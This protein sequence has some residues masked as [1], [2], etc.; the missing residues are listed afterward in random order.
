[1]GLA[2][3]IEA[4]WGV[5][6]HRAKRR[7]RGL[8]LELIVSVAVKIAATEELSAVSMNRVAADLGVSPMSLY[9]YVEAKEELLLLMVDSAYREPPAMVDS[10]AGW[11]AGLSGWAWDLHRLF[12][13]NTWMLHVPITG[14]PALPNQVLWLEH[15]LRSLA[16]TDLT[17]A[18]KL[19]VMMLVNGF[20]RS[21]ALLFA[22][23]TKAFV[24][25]GST[26]AE[27]MGFYG[28][29]LGKLATPEHFPAV[30]AALSAGGYDEESGPDDEFVFGL[31]RI[32]DGVEQLVA[33]R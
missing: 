8:S 30:N 28:K 5:R 9:R 21:E 17:E 32:L 11:R 20:V 15:G 24:E 4:A 19:S 2:Q 3:I 18:E 1:M 26:S 14:P 12:R 31:T 25:S 13:E 23:F 27:A 29:L 10:G 7:Q 6:D 16:G 33:G 22:E